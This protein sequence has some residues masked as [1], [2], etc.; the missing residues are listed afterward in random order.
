[1]STQHQTMVPAMPSH[2]FAMSYLTSHA[3]GL[4]TVG[5]PATT[6]HPDCHFCGHSAPQDI[7]RY[8]IKKTWYP[9]TFTDWNK[10]TCPT[11]HHICAACAYALKFGLKGFVLTPT[12]A[13]HLKPSSEE[14]AHL[15]A[16]PPEPPFALLLNCIH[17]KK[18]RL[19]ADGAKPRHLMLSGRI[20]WNREHF[21]VSY[22]V[23]ETTW[24]RARDTQSLTQGWRAI[25]QEG[26]T[27]KLWKRTDIPKMLTMICGRWLRQ[28]APL[29]S[30]WTPSMKVQAQQLPSPLLSSR[31]VLEFSIRRALI[32]EFAQHTTKGAVR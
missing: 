17:L 11:S 27:E 22:G 32:A 28:E 3:R 12:R 16:N 7:P 26:L 13:H 2:L 1:M 14:W 4:P 8:E 10:M 6:R 18:G 24:I 21:P 20:A 30:K 15:F 19:T 31:L 5:T 25:I 9:R 29:S 23:H